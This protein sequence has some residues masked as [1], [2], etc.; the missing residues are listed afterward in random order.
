[1]DTLAG[2]TLQ[3]ACF[4]LPPAVPGHPTGACPYG[5]PASG[6]NLAKA[7]AL[8]KQSRDAGRPVTVWSDTRSPTQQW[9]TYYTSFLNQIGLRASL[10]VIADADYLTT[11]GSSK[12][13][14]PQTGFADWN[15]HFPNPLDFYRRVDG[16]AIEPTDNENF[17]QINDPKINAAIAKLG[18]VPTTQLTGNAVKQ[19]QSTDEYLAR[20]AYLG[21]FG[22]PTSPF[23]M[24][25]RMNYTAAVKQPIYGWDFAS[26]Q[27]K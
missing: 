13:V 12:S 11:I 8:I 9:M 27:L 17:G 14:D 15:Q 24:S 10:K 7:K 21:V 3:P 18:P 4:F 26:F 1:M 22:Y 16:R 2:G 19:W 5:N 23:L 6:G 25:E 20:K